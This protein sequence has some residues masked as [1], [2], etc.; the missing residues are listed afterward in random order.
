VLSDFRSTVLA[1]GVVLVTYRMVRRTASGEPPQHLLRS[2]VWKLIGGRWQIVFH[3]GTPSPAPQ[4]IVPVD[5]A[6]SDAEAD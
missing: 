2:S 4:L 6:A 5:P 3:Q 1:P